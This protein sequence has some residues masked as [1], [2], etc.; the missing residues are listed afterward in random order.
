MEVQLNWREFKS[1][2]QLN[3]VGKN[4]ECRIEF[5]VKF[6]DFTKRRKRVTSKVL[7]SNEIWVNKLGCF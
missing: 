6:N 7:T 1:W 4:A 2:W 5:H 3:L